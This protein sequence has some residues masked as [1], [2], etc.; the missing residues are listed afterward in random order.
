M[1]YVRQRFGLFDF[2]QVSTGKKILVVGGTGSYAIS[3]WNNWYAATGLASQGYS[4]D[5]AQTT[6]MISTVDFANYKLVYVP[7]DSANSGG[8]RHARETLR[9]HMF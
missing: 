2:D 6:T 1:V 8:K 3:A 9:R 5:F 4:V 7:A